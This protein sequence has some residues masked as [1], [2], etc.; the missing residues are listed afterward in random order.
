M[1]RKHGLMLN[2]DAKT[3]EIVGVRKVRRN[4][5]PTDE[6][7]QLTFLTKRDLAV[8][9]IHKRETLPT[10]DDFIGKIQTLTELDVIRL[11]KA[12]GKSQPKKWEPILQSFLAWHIR[13]TKIMETARFDF[14]RESL[15][16]QLMVQKRAALAWDDPMFADGIV[17]P[18]VPIRGA[19]VQPLIVID[20][21]QG[22]LRYV[23]DE[24]VVELEIGVGVFGRMRHVKW[25]KPTT[26]G[27]KLISTLRV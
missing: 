19:D 6:R 12:N 26:A 20:L 16:G 17:Y 8:L 3:Y 15:A 14:G 11:R 21:A 22:V 1:N 24:T 23:E 25:P 2:E 4:F 18:V 9:G 5:V 7:E 13:Y 10:P 27:K